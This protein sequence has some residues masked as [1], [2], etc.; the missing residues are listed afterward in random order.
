MF[1][2]IYVYSYTC[3]SPIFIYSPIY[4]LHIYISIP[5]IHIHSPIYIYLFPCYISIPIYI[6][7]PPIIYILTLYILS[8]LYMYLFPPYPYLFPTYTYLFP[9]FILIPPPCIFIPPPIYLS[10]LHPSSWTLKIS[11]PPQAHACSTRSQPG[12]G[13]FISLPA[14][15]LTLASGHAAAGTWRLAPRRPRGNPRGNPE[16]LP[17]L[18]W[19]TGVGPLGWEGHGA[20]MRRGRPYTEWTA[21]GSWM[22]IFSRAAVSYSDAHWWIFRFSTESTRLKADK[23]LQ[24]FPQMTH[25]VEGSVRGTT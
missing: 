5:P 21:A 3:Y 24:S 2:H 10:P 20:L 13:G 25:F 22:G 8:P 18:V 23:I 9:S 4:T 1:P 14:V 16:A 17:C 7:I 6:F 12:S 15:C 19:W 11:P